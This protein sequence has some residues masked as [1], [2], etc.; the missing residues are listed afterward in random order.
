MSSRAQVEEPVGDILG[1]MDTP[2]RRRPGPVGPDWRSPHDG[3][4]CSH[5]D[6]LRTM[7][8][9]LH[10]KVGSSLAGMAMAVETAQ[11]IV[12]ADPG[13]A[14]QVLGDLRSD[15][16]ELI[17]LVRRLSADR[18]AP[19]KL[20]SL[21]TAM[22]AMVG[23]M[24]RLLADRLEISLEID[25]EASTI[26]E[27]VGWAAF[28]ILREA[29]TNVLKHSMGQHCSVVVL[30]RDDHLLVRVEDD[31][32]AIPPARGSGG[33]GLANMA[34]RAAEHG[35]WCTARPVYPSGFAVVAWF[36][37]AVDKSE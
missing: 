26:P 20:C 11:R 14:R 9:D 18:E 28:W 6:A 25:Q 21:P 2:R 13:E 37:L 34:D 16:A 1:A 12:G 30:V 23:R 15:M 32:A 35:G 29:L 4:A 17:T 10:D 36:P 7:R 24:S 8:R 22:R 33:F 31:G 27:D 3:Q 5:N 19:T